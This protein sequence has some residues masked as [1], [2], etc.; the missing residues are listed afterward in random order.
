[1]RA[2][3]G[4][5]LLLLASLLASPAM[6]QVTGTLFD[7]RDG[8]GIHDPGEP[9]LEAVQVELYGTP[10]AG[11]FVDQS[12]DT[13]SDGNFSFA[14]GNGCYLLGI[15]DPPGWRLSQARED[16]FVDGTTPYLPPVGQP[17]FT[18][19]DK[20]IAN[21]RAGAIRYSSIGDSIAF[22]FNLCS[23]VSDFWYSRQIRSRIACTD[24]LAMV[25]LDEGAVKGE[26][27]DD[28]L[29]N[30]GSPTDDMNN[31]FDVIA[32][33]PELVSISIIGNDLL[34]AEP[35]GTPDQAATNHAVIEVL[36]SR[37]N[38]QEILSTLLTQLPDT[39]IVLNTLYDNEAENCYADNPSLFHRT[40]VPIV[41]RI[42]RDT[43]WGQARRVTNA[44][45]AAE[46][47]HEDQL[48]NCTG[49]DD[50]L[51]CYGFLGL[52]QIHPTNPGFEII[53]EKLWEGIGGVN[54]GSQDALGRT[55]IGDVDF[56]YLRRVRR[57]LPTA[58]ETRNGAAVVNPEAALDDEDGG[59]PVRITLGAGTEELR[60]DGFPD[61]Y[62]EVEIVR[63]VAGVRYRTTG[64]VND[65]FYR[66][67]ASINET[68]RPDA[69][70]AYTPTSWNFFT[71]IV[72]GGGPNQPPDED[73]V[74]SGN[75]VLAYPDVPAYRDVSAL[76]TKNP[77]LPGGASD[78]EWP[79][80]THEELATTTIR[81][82][83]APVA[84]TAGNDT[85]QVE[86]D[87]AW[88]DL[89]GWEKERPDEVGQVE[90]DRLGDGT[91]EVSFEPVTDAQRY[92][93]YFGRLSKVQG[94]EYDHGDDAPAGPICDA[95]TVDAGDG[96]LKIVVSPGSQPEGDAYVI[97]TA[98]VDDV[99]SPAGMRSDDEERDRSQSTCR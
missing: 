31:V 61:W 17:R 73:P 89:Y 68:F 19:L 74:Y 96:R 52:D 86:L 32:A 67:E 39:D 79:A 48:G 37:Q 91:M 35:S 20:A 93:L 62:D 38:L 47:G 71:P 42:L 27:T 9:A 56:G 30:D 54:L 3:A 88:L 6:A 70:H 82:A 76:L 28:L 59:A 22:N 5:G 99:E 49:F 36:D 24:P 97:V 64:T 90:I 94:G 44:E 18:K 14:P 60:L 8:D 75:V 41:S 98:H 29:I 80:V 78:Y 43:A 11:G 69:G 23:P 46:F 1:V 95:A 45:I 77:E 33:D 53:R 84:G 34:D 72:G 63:V 83:S 7:D 58:Y 87:Y 81:I 25:T 21:L 50:D 66:M 85:Y 92:N 65:D 12:T 55:S 16:G 15:S 26:H 13:D 57:L 4:I 10:D 2:R 40:W 51:I